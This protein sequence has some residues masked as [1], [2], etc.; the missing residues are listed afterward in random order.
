MREIPGRVYA[1]VLRTTS[2]GSSALCVRLAETEPSTV[3]ATVP[4]PRLPTTI[5]AARAERAAAASA[6]QG[7]GPGFDG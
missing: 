7:P 3:D 1:S 5:S 6:R 4:R 2:T